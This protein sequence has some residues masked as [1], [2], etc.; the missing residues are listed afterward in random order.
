MARE[1]T[2]RF[3]SLSELSRLANVTGSRIIQLHDAGVVKHDA[4]SGN[5]FLFRADRVEE[6]TRTIRNYGLEKS[7]R[8]NSRKQNL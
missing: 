2:E 7:I 4:V 6:L 3:V 1:S 5:S 8:A